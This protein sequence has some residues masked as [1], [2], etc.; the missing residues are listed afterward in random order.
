M[1]LRDLHQLSATG[2]R[3][4]GDGGPYHQDKCTYARVIA[5]MN[6]Q[7]S[8]QQLLSIRN[9]IVEVL[10]HADT[11]R[12]VLSIL[13]AGAE[14]DGPG[15]RFVRLW[16]D[17][18]IKLTNAPNRLQCSV[19]LQ[20]PRTETLS[21]VARLIYQH[22][23]ELE[24]VFFMDKVG[25]LRRMPVSI[26]L[27]PDL[28]LFL[29]AY[30]LRFTPA[31][32]TFVFH[33]AVEKPWPGLSTEF[34]AFMTG[35]TVRLPLRLFP[36]Q[37]MLRRIGINAL[38]VKHNFKHEA[39]EDLAHMSRHSVAIL[40][41]NYTTWSSV[42]QQRASTSASASTQYSPCHL[43]QHVAPEFVAKTWAAFQKRYPLLLQVPDT[44]LLVNDNTSRALDPGGR[45]ELQAVRYTGARP[46]C[47]SCHERV[48]FVSINE[49]RCCR[50]SCYPTPHEW[51]ET[52]LPAQYALP[53]IVLLDVLPRRKEHYNRRDLLIRKENV[54]ARYRHITVSPTV[55]SLHLGLDLSPH[56]TSMCIMKSG[57]PPVIW[58]LT[59]TATSIRTTSIIPQIR[60]G[61]LHEQLCRLVLAA[62]GEVS[63]VHIAY[64]SPLPHSVIHSEDQ[65]TFVESVI[66]HLQKRLAPT[67]SF[68][69]FDNRL[70][71]TGWRRNFGTEQI[72]DHHLWK[73]N[74]RTTDVG[75]YDVCDRIRTYID[76]H[77]GVDDVKHRV[78]KKAAK[79]I[80]YIL[81]RGRG[82]HVLGIPVLPVEWDDTAIETFVP[83]VS[84]HPV[85][86][87]VDAY[88]IARHSYLVDLYGCTTPV[89]VHDPEPE[90][91]P[92]N[93]DGQSSGDEDDNDN[94][95]KKD[96][97]N[98][99]F[100]L[101]E[102]LDT[103]RSLTLKSIGK[104]V[105]YWQ[106]QLTT[107]TWNHYKHYVGTR[108]IV[109][110]NE[111]GVYIGMADRG[112]DDHAIGTEGFGDDILEDDDPLDL[113]VFIRRSGEGSYAELA[114]VKR[115]MGRWYKAQ[116]SV[117]STNVNQ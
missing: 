25:K 23:T 51:F 6:T 53:D 104:K 39:L 24:R 33:D 35:E 45:T 86:D 84:A 71:K 47:S 3:P 4:D 73:G 61:E 78:A 54:G 58:Y 49:H 80:N 91:E 15:R 66:A 8:P 7:F 65:R 64:E 21:P 19:Q 41:N 57:D 27:G 40:L 46:L 83:L 48:Q 100:L 2:Q 5:S 111:T 110:D 102:W 72:Q 99:G 94:E 106:I 81:W 18:L 36:N 116:S 31:K 67:T 10:S 26:P 38:A 85:S 70:I 75:V 30:I 32:C 37:K 50:L 97:E 105:Y 14:K 34:V 1:L 69:A 68:H 117:L 113:F 96:V 12:H 42:H 29:A 93:V 92:E 90:P 13:Q 11:V 87:I 107:A 60:E 114:R 44:P 59:T 63:N 108:V 76:Q 82:L 109:A 79:L 20:L 17:V 95:E 9:H 52:M 101:D 16:L 28:S 43:L 74:D 112:D 88:M 115:E 56:G 22:P 89:T 62:V 77:S 103:T 98:E 55:R